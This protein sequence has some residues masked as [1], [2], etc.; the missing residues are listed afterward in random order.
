MDQ[1][2]LKP[3]AQNLYFLSIKVVQE[4]LDNWNDRFEKGVEDTNYVGDVYGLLG[5]ILDFVP[6]DSKV[7]ARY[8]WAK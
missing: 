3:T 5:G 4:I 6:L 7:S 8:H 2:D 1:G